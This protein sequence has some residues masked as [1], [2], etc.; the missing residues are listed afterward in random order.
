MLS[1]TPPKP[2][3]GS[4]PVRTLRIG[5]RITVYGDLEIVRIDGR[6]VT[7]RL[8]NSFTPVMMPVNCDAVHR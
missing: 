8:H 6:R 3:D 7:V 4:G 1:P 2:A 5:D